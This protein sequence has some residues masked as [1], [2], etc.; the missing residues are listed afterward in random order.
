MRPPARFLTALAQALSTMGLYKE[1]HPARERAAEAVHERILELQ[2][3]SVLN[4][5]TFLPGQVVHDD[6]PVRELR[7][8]DWSERLGKL[9]VERVEF[10]G[11]VSRDDLD[12]F[13]EDIL[14][15]LA[16]QTIPSAEVRQMR[17]TSIRY[18]LAA[19]KGDED[20]EG[21]ATGRDE[22]LATATL[23]FTLSDEAD[24]VR[25]LHEE[26]KDGK[27]LELLEAEAV[28]RSLSVAMH[29]DQAFLLPLL[30]LKQ[31][32]QYTT[33]HALNVSVLAMALAEHI[34]LAPAEVRAFGI[35][36]LLHDLGKTRIPEEIL[37][38]PGKLT[39]QEREI[40]NSHTVEGA[41]LI[42]EKDHHLDLAAVVAYEHHIRID[43][44]GY[45]TLAFPRQCH[46]CS[47]LIHVC[48]VFDALRTDRP[49]RDAW[50]QD[51][52]IEYIGDRAGSEFEPE[53]ARAFVDMMQKLDGRV[54]ELGAED[55]AV[56]AEAE[57][58][59]DVRYVD[60]ASEADKAAGEGEGEDG[61]KPPE[62]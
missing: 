29:G 56:E 39:D 58:E 15:R 1:G 4:E 8:W 33:T 40:M 55:E 12:W 13:L 10:T 3:A 6:R 47:N 21:K 61:E 62:R 19:M 2:E 26:L 46:Q 5:F 52:V 28:V 11:P 42:M 50:E 51:Q 60:S 48:D 24:T 35:S 57:W 54:V 37:N 34:G 14:A 30:H 31:F 7:E 27:E 59:R 44:G 25:W 9:G 18:G 53:L 45:P 36:G 16:E 49:Y 17:K 43:G 41:R 20:P 22:E 32:D 38:K 23:G